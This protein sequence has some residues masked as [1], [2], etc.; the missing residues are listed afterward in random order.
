MAQNET[1]SPGAVVRP[2][3]VFLAALVAGLA[4]H[5]A[6]PMRILRRGWLQPAI[7]LPLIGIAVTLFAWA[8]RTMGKEGTGVRSTDL[9]TTIV[10]HGPFRF[11]RNP[12]YLSFGLGLMG[13]ATAVNT[14]WIILLVPIETAIISAQIKREEDYLERKFGDE[15]LRYKAEVRRWL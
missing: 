13:F 8:F 11:S 15:Y 12:I 14:P 3:L 2:P 1:D 9:T 7:G 5:F 6:R 4:L 10:T